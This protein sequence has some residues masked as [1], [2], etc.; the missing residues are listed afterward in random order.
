MAIDVSNTPDMY[1]ISAS[2]SFTFT[3]KCGVRADPNMDTTPRAYYAIGQTVYYTKKVKNGNHFWLSYLATSGNVSYVPYA[4]TDT[5]E[6]FGTDSNPVDPIQASDGGSTGTGTGTGTGTT[7]ILG[8]LTGSTGAAVADQTADG[9]TLVESGSFT[10]TEAAAGR[11]ETLM[12]ATHT[13]SFKAGETVYYNAKVKADGHYWFRY[14]HTSGATYYVPYATIDPFRYYGTDSNP[15]DPIYSVGGGS[16]TGGS[17]GGSTGTSRS[18]TGQDTGLENL[19]SNDSRTFIGEGYEY[20]SV[21][22]LTITSNAWGRDQPLMTGAKQIKKYLAGTKINYNAKLFNDGHLWVVLRNGQYLPVST[23]A[24]VQNAGKD[25][26]NKANYSYVINDTGKVQPIEVLWPYTKAMQHGVS[27]VSNFE[28]NDSIVDVSSTTEISPTSIELDA[29]QKLANEVNATA[30]SQSVSIAYI[31]DTHFDSYET[32]ASAHVLHSMQL[33]SYFSK[34][35]GVDL[36]IHGGDLN[37]GSKPKSISEGDV[38]RAMDAMKMGQR[39]FFVLQGNHDDNS[40]YARDETAN[41]AD[42]IITNSEALALRRNYFSKWLQ[43]PSNNPNNA[44]FGRYDVP[45]SN[46][47]VLVLDGFDMPDASTP[48][49]YT[50]RHGH[51]AYSSAQQAWLK[52]TLAT[53]GSERK[54][55]VFD[56]IALNGI[57]P[58]AWAQYDDGLFEN[59]TYAHYVAGVATSKNIYNILTQHQSQFNNILGFFAGHTHI[60]NNAISG[61]I[62]FVTSTCGLADRGTGREQRSIHDLSENGWEII[63]INPTK[64]EIIQYRLPSDSTGLSSGHTDGNFKKTWHI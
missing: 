42:Q 39:P 23:I 60:D 21:S 4:N 48:D 45:N 20:P 58:H 57:D 29:M 18:H 40:G 2:G 35:Y 10:F 44:V 47:T 34:H 37:D 12:A 15:G 24:N 54:V 62:Q 3:T 50:M 31:T 19:T 28:S 51:T 7:G 63:Q 26:N 5:G 22:S 36:M 9:T 61:G 11:A 32:P 6:Y 43:I 52:A 25:E 46:V 17:T 8:Q 33:M 59:F 1:S 64:N 49:R 41:N 53:L 16:S 30:D 27:N 56:H 55:V 13:D 14:V 38:R